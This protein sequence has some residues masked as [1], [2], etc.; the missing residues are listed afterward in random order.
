MNRLMISAAAVLTASVFSTSNAAE[1]KNLGYLT[2]SLG[3]RIA[4]ETDTGFAQKILCVF[5]L[6]GTGAEELYGGTA[7]LM[8]AP[9]DDTAKESALS[10]VVSAPADSLHAPGGLEQTY[11]AKRD[12]AVGGGSSARPDPTLIGETLAAITLHPLSPM[13]DP[14]ADIANTRANVSIIDLKLRNTAA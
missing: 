13:G 3:E 7:Y 4:S 8:E 14:S 9:K 11:T 1:P 2:C 12:P 10:W 6:E 5:R